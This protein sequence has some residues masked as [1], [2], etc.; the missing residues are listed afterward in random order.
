[1][2]FW[3]TV[4][5]ILFFVGHANAELEAKKI[6]QLLE[7]TNALELGKQIGSSVMD[8]VSHLYPKEAQP[9]LQRLNDSMNDDE[10]KKLIIGL[11]QENFTEAEVDA[12]IAFYSSEQGKSIITKMPKVVQESMQIGGAYGQ[13]KMRELLEEMKK[14]GY[15]PAKI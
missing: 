13:I 1:M 12:M 14:E 10:F 2:K 15:E 7:L 9:L 5:A 6:E 3:A 8:Q 4:M 11:Y